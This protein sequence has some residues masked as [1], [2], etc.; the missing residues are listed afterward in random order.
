MA[1]DKRNLIFGAQDDIRNAKYVRIEAQL[2]DAKKI[3]LAKT[4]F[5]TDESAVFSYLIAKG[6][7]IGDAGIGFGQ[8]FTYDRKKFLR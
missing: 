4:A 7:F 3:R 5:S 1:L 2:S 6:P 8:T